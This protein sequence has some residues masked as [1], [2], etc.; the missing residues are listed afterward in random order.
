MSAIYLDIGAV[1]EWVRRN[2]PEL[3]IVREGREYRFMDSETKLD[4]VDPLNSFNGQAVKNSDLS[5]YASMIQQ[6]SSH[7]LLKPIVQAIEE[8]ISIVSRLQAYSSVWKIAA[9][10]PLGAGKATL[11][12]RVDVQG[13]VE[14]SGP[15]GTEIATVPIKLQTGADI[16]IVPV[17]CTGKRSTLRFPLHRLFES[18]VRNNVPTKVIYC[19]VSYYSRTLLRR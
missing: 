6:T 3:V 7:Q 12:A 9:V 10:F 18:M 15:K 1:A 2:V 13:I 16:Y 4:A 11:E 5:A 19:V 8:Y 17:V 14:G